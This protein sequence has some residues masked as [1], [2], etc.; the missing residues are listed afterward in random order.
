MNCEIY[1][2]VYGK[3]VLPESMIFAGGAEDVSH[4]ITFTI[5]YIHS[6]DRHI[7]VDAGCDTMD[8]WDMRNFV[9]PAAAL[10]RI[11][12]DAREI[13]DVIISHS[14]HDHIEG[15]HHFPKA[16]VYIQE[17]ELPGAQP[18]LT[19]KEGI[20][21]FRDECRVAGCVVR[22]IGGHSLG[23]CVVTLKTPHTHYVF[24]GDECYYQACL[25]R[26]IPTGS[27]CNP[28]NSQAF[29][30]TYASPEY[31]ALLAH[32]PGITTRKII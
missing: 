19:G 1:A 10:S 5:Y 13:T 21:A 3:S 16:K 6:G 28:H 30:D 12:V 31:T 7:L 14:H 24:C 2:V 9:T 11:G 23:S 22:K 17:D 15:L 25:D 20:I 32:D 29:I 18:Y 27:S 4:P 8:G 26:K